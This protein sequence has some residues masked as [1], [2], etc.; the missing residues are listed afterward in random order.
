MHEFKHAFRPG[1]RQL[2]NI[3]FCNRNTEHFQ[4]PSEII[5]MK[6][7][8]LFISTFLFVVL[9]AKGADCQTYSRNGM[10]VSSNKTASEVGADILK[11]GGNAIDA[12]VATAF[13]LAVTHPTAGNIGGGGFLVFMNTSG[14]TTT[15]DFREKA[16]LKASPTMFLDNYGNLPVGKNLHGRESTSNHIGAKSIGVPGTVAGLYLAHQKYGSLPWADLVQPAIDLAKNGFPLTWSHFRDATHF[17][18]NSPIAFFN[19]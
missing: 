16:P 19:R 7:L 12:S 15:I 4:G 6:Y 14:K 8:N 5:T 9:H 17:D 18:A 13:A 2:R 3:Q 11:K 10:V 1:S